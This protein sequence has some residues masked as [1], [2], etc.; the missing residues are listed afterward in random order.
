MRTAV[1]SFF[2]SQNL[3]D[4]LLA[5]RLAELAARHFEVVPISYGSRHPVPRA[6]QLTPVL[7]RNQN[8]QQ[9]LLHAHPWL[10]AQ[11]L[12]R[13]DWSSYAIGHLDTV[14]AIVIGGGNM[15]FDTNRWTRSAHHFNRIVA[16]A[17]DADI[18]VF[19]AALGIGPFTT[20]RQQLSAIDGIAG[21]QLRSFRDQQSIGLF[22]E[23]APDHA[24][25]LSIDPVFGLP[26]A[27]TTNTQADGGVIAVNLL[28]S[29]LVGFSRAQ[30][31]RHLDWL[32]QIVAELKL[33][34]GR[35]IE[36][37][38]TEMNDY[39]ALVELAPRC[40]AGIHQVTGLADLQALYARSAVV[41]AC[42]M[43]SLIIAA[44]QQV[45]VVGMS[46]QPKVTAF[47]DLID[48]PAAVHRLGSAPVNDVVSSVLER[49]NPQAEREERIA[50]AMVRARARC[51]VDEQLM[52]E[53]AQLV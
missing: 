41:L 33:S 39:P 34:T 1:I 10:T 47:F 28:D 49:M 37:F 8:R 4:L 11:I 16:A 2:T 13:H 7:A 51:Q 50:A 6:Q 21:C 32:A 15:L 44:T 36:L 35:T 12:R 25:E 43:H 53:F 5:E 42:R 9:R 30:Y 46:W 23:L 18:P 19:A 24:A 29:T 14:D 22:H 27:P 17:R 31:E 52:A 48:D 40:G 20:L 45:P 3:G 38:S 26:P